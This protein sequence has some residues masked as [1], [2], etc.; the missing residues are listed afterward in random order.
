MRPA[1][2]FLCTI[3]VSFL[4]FFPLPADGSLM[5]ASMYKKHV[6]YRLFFN[7]R[8][9]WCL[10]FFDPFHLNLPFKLWGTLLAY[11]SHMLASIYYKKC[12]ISLL[13][14]TRD[15]ARYLHFFIHLSTNGSHIWYICA[16]SIMSTR[17]YKRN[18]TTYMQ[19]F[20]VFFCES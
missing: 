9:C 1:C 15:I 7:P 4:G 2:Q 8:Y 16:V 20:C 3:I 13:F 11:G 5:S 18:T 12:V 14:F 6:I 17:E 10:P 19:N